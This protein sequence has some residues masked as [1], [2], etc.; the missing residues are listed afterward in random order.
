MSADELM[1]ALDPRRRRPTN[2]SALE[3]PDGEDTDPA[4]PTLPPVD[5]L[6]KRESLDLYML[7]LE[8][9]YCPVFA[10][11]LGEWPPWY[12]RDSRAIRNALRHIERP[13]DKRA[14]LQRFVGQVRDHAASIQAR[15]GG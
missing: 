2:W 4:L 11:P 12:I 6:V 7:E 9:P 14:A 1:A 5:G 10:G 13:E 8:R 15:L 3:D